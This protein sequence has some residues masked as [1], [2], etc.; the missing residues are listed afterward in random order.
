MPQ[1]IEITQSDVAE[2]ERSLEIN[3]DDQRRECI[4]CRVTR[5]VQACPGSGK[6][7]L[8]VAKLAILARKW[9]WRDRG[10]CVL[11]HTNAARREVEQ[12]LSGYPAAHRLL[13]YPHFVGTIQAFVDKFLAIPHLRNEG[14]D[15]SMI[16]DDR[17]AEKALR[18]LDSHYTA[19]A[20]LSHRYNGDDIVAGLRFEGPNLSLSSAGGTIPC[21]EHTPTHKELTAIKRT[22]YDEGVLRYDDMYAFA[23][24]YATDHPWVVEAVRHRFPW[25]FIDEMQDTDAIQDRLLLTLFGK[26][27]ILHRFGDSNQAI[28]RGVEVESQTS[29]P[30]AP[31][32]DLPHSRRFGQQIADLASP[33]AAVTPQDLVGSSGV[34]SKR[35]TVFLFDKKTVL[36]VL[37]AFGKLI[38]EEYATGLPAEFVAKAIGFRKTPPTQA[39]ADKAP[40]SIGH[41]HPAFLP[42]TTS[43]SYRPKSLVECVRRA[44]YL[45][46]TQSECDQAFDVLI[47]GVL[48]FLGACGGRDASGSRFTRTRL[49]DALAAAEGNLLPRFR[50]LLGWMMLGTKPLTL[51]RWSVT[52]AKLK[53]VLQPWTGDRLSAPAQKF[54]AWS[55][56]EQAPA[57][58]ECAA[59]GRRA[60]AYCLDSSIGPVEILLSTIHGA[61]GQTHTATMVL[62]TYYKKKHDL[63]EVLPF[64]RGQ[65]K[66]MTECL[67]GHMKRIF[68]AMTRPRELLCLAIRKDHVTAGDAQALAARG[69]AICDL[70]RSGA[71]Q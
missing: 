53:D 24:K 55:A 66:P 17:F 14:L 28:F 51:D 33:L 61:K 35:H 68:V 60:D 49:V 22:L 32:L 45:C 69:W 26:D 10:I 40:F 56:E 9:T 29:F 39:E 57:D 7:T 41:Y 63:K 70:M 4:R 3:L 67:R 25:V 27:C 21:G 42:S 19:K 54:T 64:L 36:E 18:L 34:P 2:I 12:R 43:L 58:G 16:D 37:P 30:R 46:R 23:E 1:Q 15:I 59:S 13:G 20:F 71:G 52:V 31:H 11:S 65:T 6:T 5:D 38:S 48:E 47:E 8:L 50:S 44:R 62:E